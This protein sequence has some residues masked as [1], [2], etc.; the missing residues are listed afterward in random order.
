[1]AS[2]RA[3]VS[4]A[5]SSS[6]R[7]A[8]EFGARDGATVP[9]PI[10]PFRHTSMKTSALER[11]RADLAAGRPDQARERLTGYLYTLHR[12]GRYDQTTYLLLGDV[13]FAMHDFA[14]AGAA[15]LLTEKTGPE[16]DR[17]TAAF[18]QRFGRDPANVLMQVKPHAPSEAYP[19]VVQE[20]LKSWDYRYRPY[21]PRSNPHALTEKSAD[22][23]GEKRVRPV[24]LGC[25]VAVVIFALAF[26]F[27]IVVSSRN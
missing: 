24:E 7:D 26:I 10:L 1:M 25:I 15:W 17:A 11:A 23:S 27:W 19:A 2:S 9:C 16:A 8:K 20:R 22:D 5:A 13:C 12:A 18:Y 4:R 14:R 6:A 3:V 21:R